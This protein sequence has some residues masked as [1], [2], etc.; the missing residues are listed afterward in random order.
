MEATEFQ[1]L[2]IAN[3][4]TLQHVKED[5]NDLKTNIREI[6]NTLKILVKHEEKLFKHEEKFVEIT[7][8]IKQLISS[9]P[10]VIPLEQQIKYLSEE[11]KTMK[12]DIKKVIFSILGVFGGLVILIIKDYLGFKG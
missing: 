6:S 11:Q 12:A 5:M 8:Q 1:Q 2:I 4:I 9:T 7:N 10:V 3:N